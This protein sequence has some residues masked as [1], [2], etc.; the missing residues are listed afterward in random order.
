MENVG[1]IPSNALIISTDGEERGVK[2]WKKCLLLWTFKYTKVDLT[3]CQ[4]VRLSEEAANL[5]QR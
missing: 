2:L 5:V 3:Y 4:F 1:E